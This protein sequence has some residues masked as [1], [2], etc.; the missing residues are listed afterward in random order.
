MVESKNVFVLIQH[1]KYE[2][3]PGNNRGLTG[4]ALCSRML[5]DRKLISSC[6]SCFIKVANYRQV[7]KVGDGSIKEVCYVP[8]RGG[9]H[10]AFVLTPPLLDM[11]PT[12]WEQFMHWSIQH[13]KGKTI[14]AHI[15]KI[16]MAEC[17]YGIWIERN[18]RIFVQKSRIVGSVAKEIAYVSI[19]RSQ[20]S[21]LDEMPVN[22]SRQ[23]LLSAACL[24]PLATLFIQQRVASTAKV[25]AILHA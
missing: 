1:D 19:I 3:S 14:S 4:N 24:C 20:P 22:N 21:I 17:V 13:A 18:N 15:F 23:E 12:N 25:W 11:L 2:I 5:R 16:I 8:K 6:G 10:R 9:N 7:N